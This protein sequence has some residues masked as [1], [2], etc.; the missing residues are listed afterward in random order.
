MVVF[1]FV[2][3]PGIH[4]IAI[5]LKINALQFPAIEKLMIYL[6]LKSVKTLVSPV[7]EHPLTLMS[8]VNRI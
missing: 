1:F 2:R 3:D 4:G 7:P 5:L 6:S 8:K